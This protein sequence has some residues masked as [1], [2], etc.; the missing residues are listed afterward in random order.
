MEELVGK[1]WLHN[2]WLLSRFGRAFLRSHFLVRSIGPPENPFTAPMDRWVVFLLVWCLPG[3]PLAIMTAVYTGYLFAQAKARDMW[4]NP[5]LPPHLLVQAIL[6][7]SAILLPISLWLSPLSFES[8]RPLMVL[9]S[10]STLIHL[11]MIWGESFRWRIPP[12][13]LGLQFGK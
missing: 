10:I 13:T 1:R 12:P 6:L 9:L 7:G 3:L 4:Q 5:L 11:L 8:V 2:F